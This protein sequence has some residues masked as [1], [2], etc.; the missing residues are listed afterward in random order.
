VFFI[1]AC[2]FWSLM[3]IAVHVVALYGLCAYGSHAN[4][5]ALSVVRKNLVEG[6]RSWCG[7]TSGPDR[8]RG[9]GAQRGLRAD[10]TQTVMSGG[11]GGW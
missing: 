10:V 8:S 3:I 4:L 1:P 6:R 2:P 9:P 7:L 5:A 11:F